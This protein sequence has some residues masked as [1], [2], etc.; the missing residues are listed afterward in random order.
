MGT[1]AWR[2]AGLDSSRDAGCGLTL[3]H[4]G[5]PDEKRVDPRGFAGPV[6]RFMPDD[7]DNI[8][9]ELLNRNQL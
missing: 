3:A 8:R 7:S 1:A 9:R 2:D 6:A 4:T 5:L